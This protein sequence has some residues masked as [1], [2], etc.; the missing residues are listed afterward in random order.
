MG[1]FAMADVRNVC[2]LVL[3]NRSFDHMLGF[4]AI[5]GFDAATGTPTAV[6]GLDGTQSNEYQGQTYKV[7]CPAP[8]TMPVDPG[9][10]FADVLMQLCGPLAA[11]APHKYPPM[12]NSGFVVDYAESPSPEEGK[13]SGN[14]GDIMRCL[15]PEQLPVLNTLAREF[16]V[17]DHWHS[18]MPGPTWPKPIFR[19]R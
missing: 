11:Y 17:C 16:A 14:Y 1:E 2:V 7:S 12:N 6:D 8:D 5:T 9:H 10:E 18:S 13:A 3:E 15:S 19:A 4:S